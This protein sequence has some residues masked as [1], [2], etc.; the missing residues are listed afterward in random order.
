VALS[1]LARG[2]EESARCM[3]GTV[4]NDGGER[5]YETGEMKTVQVGDGARTFNANNS[6]NLETFRNRKNSEK[7]GPRKD[8]I[9]RIHILTNSHSILTSS[10]TRTK[11]DL[12]ASS[13]KKSLLKSVGK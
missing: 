2:I 8:Q 3:V 13:G 5:K 11:H 10:R 6:K 4:D 12:Y 7:L 9:R 1:A